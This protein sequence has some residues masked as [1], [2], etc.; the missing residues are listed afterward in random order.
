MERWFGKGNDGQ[1]ARPN[2]RSL[3]RCE[4]TGLNCDSKMKEGLDAVTSGPSYDCRVVESGSAQVSCLSG[5]TLSAA[6]DRWRC[7]SGG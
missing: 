2:W 3:G 7:S 1:K 4:L 6:P 5:G